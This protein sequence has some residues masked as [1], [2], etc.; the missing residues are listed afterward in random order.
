MGILYVNLNYSEITQKT[1]NKKHLNL[2]WLLLVCLEIKY[3]SHLMTIITV[4]NYNSFFID[5]AYM[6][7]NE[8]LT[9]DLDVS[10]YVNT[11][12]LT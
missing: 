1:P 11:Y 5:D 10:I 8:F 6:T 7:A 3:R 12:C 4:N 9:L 2:Y